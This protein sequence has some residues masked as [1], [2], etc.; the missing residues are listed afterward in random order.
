MTRWIFFDICPLPY[1]KLTNYISV[2]KKY[3]EENPR[4]KL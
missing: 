4:L 1:P 3:L 2:Q